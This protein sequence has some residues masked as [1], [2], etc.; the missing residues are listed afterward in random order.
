MARIRIPPPDVPAI[1]PATGRFTRDWYDVLKGLERLGLLDLAG[2]VGGTPSNG[3][4]L[5]YQ[6]GS[7]VLE[8]PATPSNGQK[9]TW[10]TANNRW[11]AV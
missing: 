3:Q 6:S 5:A 7:W 9:L 2:V 8:P 10:D 11:T 1:D 4:L